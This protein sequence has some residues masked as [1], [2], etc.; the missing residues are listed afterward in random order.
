MSESN[1]RVLARNTY[2]LDA[3]GVVAHLRDTVAAYLSNAGSSAR[4]TAL[5]LPRSHTGPARDVIERHNVTDAWR[6]R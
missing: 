4:P 6:I 1:A 3:S 5:G 2:S